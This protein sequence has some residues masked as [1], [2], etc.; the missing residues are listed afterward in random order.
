MLYREKNHSNPIVEFNIKL[1]MKIV[2]QFVVTNHFVE[3]I[4]SK[5]IY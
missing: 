4:S 3:D 2:K 1:C 5:N